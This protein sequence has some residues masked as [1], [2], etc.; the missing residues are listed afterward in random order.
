MKPTHCAFPRN[1]GIAAA[2]LLTLGT[3][4]Q[5]YEPDITWP[6]MASRTINTSL[7]VG[8]IAGVPSVTQTGAA[9][10]TIPILVPPGTNGVVPQL[11][12]VYNSQGG[13][14]LL[15]YG[16]NLS[17]LST[18]SRTGRD[19]YH[20]GATGP[21]TLSNDDRF[22]LDGQ[23]L[24]CIS[25]TY[26]VPGSTYDTESTSFA[27]I[28]LSSNGNTEA[29]WYFSV[30]TK[31]GITME[32]GLDWNA[33]ILSNAEDKAIAWRLNRT[34]DVYGNYIDYLYSSNDGDSWLTEVRYT[35][36]L[37]SFSAPYNNITF[38]YQDRIDKNEQFMA[39]EPLG[40][41]NLLSGITVSAH[42]SLVRAYKLN[43][44][45]RYN[46][47][48]YLNEVQE[49]GSDGIKSYNPTQFL[50]NTKG[51]T[52]SQVTTSTPQTVESDIF[53][54]D[55]DGNGQ[56]DK[57]VAR[58]IWNN[59]YR[60]HDYFNIYLNGSTQASPGGYHDFTT[61]SEIMMADSYWRGLSSN[62]LDG[63]GRDDILISNVSLQSSIVPNDPLQ[64]WSNYPAAW[65]FESFTVFMSTSTINNAS[66]SPPQQFAPPSVYSYFKKPENFL[67]LGDFTGDGRQDA[68]VIFN[69]KNNSNVSD[70]FLFSNNAW[71]ALNL[72]S[73]TTNMVSHV[74]R[75]LGGDYDGDG[76]SELFALTDHIPG[77]PMY[78]AL[79]INAGN[80]LQLVKGGLFR[81]HGA[82][83]KFYVHSGDF[84]G[85]H[86]TDFLVRDDDGIDDGSEDDW[87]IYTG[88]G[89]KDL[90]LP[91]YVSYQ[92]QLTDAF[93]GSQDK[94]I[95]ADFD[96]NG[97][98]DIFHNFNST[99][100]N[101]Q[102]YF[103]YGHD[104][105]LPIFD[106]SVSFYCSKNLS[107][108][109][110]GDFNGDAKHDL[111]CCNSMNTELTSIQFDPVSRERIL[112]AVSN[113]LCERVDFNYGTLNELSGSQYNRGSQYEYPL[114]YSQ[115]PLN[116]VANIWQ[117][118]GLGSQS[119]TWY[120]YDMAR[121]HRAG[122]G[123]LGFARIRAH[124]SEL[125]TTVETVKDF[126][127]TY[128][129][130]YVT[131]EY[132]RAYS[133]QQLISHKNYQYQYISLGP[134]SD[135]RFYQK[136]TNTT[137][138]NGLS[139]GTV[140]TTNVWDAYGNITWCIQN[141]SN[142]LLTT[143]TSSTFAHYGPGLSIPNRIIATTVTTI[144]DGQAALSKATSF[145][146]DGTTGGLI[147]LK[148]F[149]GTGKELTTDYT[150]DGRGL[151]T[152]E[153]S[154][155]AGASSLEHRITDYGY[156]ALGQFVDERTIQWNNSGTLVPVVD[157]FAYDAKWGVPLENTGP[158][159][160]T[161]KYT[162]DVFGRGI[163]FSVPHVDGSPRYSITKDLDWALGGNEYY[164]E[165][166]EHP[167]KPVR[168]TFYDSFGRSVRKRVEVNGPGD[169]SEIKITYDVRG[170]VF[171]E[172]QA[173]L[174]NEQYYTVERQYDAYNR[175]TQEA[176][177]VFGATSYDYNYDGNGAM[178]RTV[179]S[180]SGAAQESTTD[181]SGLLTKAVDGGGEQEYTYDSW[182]NLLRVRLNGSTASICKYDAYGRQTSLWDP[183]AGSTTYEYDA[184]GQLVYQEDAQS[185]ITTFGYD[186]LGR[187]V[188][189]DI[190]GEVTTWDY[191]FDGSKFS[192]DLRR[193]TGHAA[194][195][196]YEYDAYF[197]VLKETK[198]ISGSPFTT[199]FEYDDYNNAT[200]Q[201]YPSGLEIDYTYRADGCIDK[202]AYNG[203][204]LFG[205][206]G[207][208]G[209]GQYLSYT[210]GS[211]PLSYKEYYYGLPTHFQTAGIQD[212]QM[213]WDPNTLNLNYRWDKMKSRKE[214]FAYDML[215][216][217]TLSTVTEVDG[218]GNVVAQ[219][220]ETDFNYDGNIG[221][222]KGNLTWKTDV[223]QFKYNANKVTGAVN[224]AYPTPAN[225]PPDV[226]N[227]SPQNI[228]YTP[229]HQPAQI[230]ENVN[231]TDYSLEYEY[232]ADLHRCHSTLNAGGALEESR[233]Y[234]G[235]FE[236]QE[237]VSEGASREIHYVYGGDGIC[238]VLVTEGGATQIYHVFKDH[239]GSLVALVQEAGGT[240]NISAEQNFDA[241][242]R[243][244]NAQDWSTSG[245]VSTPSW[246]Y[247]GYTGH[248]HVEPFAL[249]NMNG[250]MYDPINGRML[251]PDNYAIGTY[252]SQTFNRYSYANNNPLKYTD[253]DGNVAI[254][255]DAILGLI[256]G[257]INLVSN[258]GNISSF[259]QGLGYFGIGFISGASSTYITPMGAAALAGALNAGFDSY[260]STGKVNAGAMI[261]G[262]VISGALGA[263]T[264]GL[265]NALA[266]LASKLLPGVASPVLRGAATQGILGAGLGGLGGGV[267]AALSGGN[268]W[269]GVGQGAAFGAA[270]GMA[271][272]AYGGFLTARA[273]GVDPWTGRAPPPPVPP[274]EP[275]KGGIGPVLKGQ[276]GVE[277]AINELQ[278]EG[279][280]NIHTEITFEV[281]GTRIRVD[282]AGEFNGEI[283]LYEVKTGPA[284]DL[285]RNQ[286]IAFPLMQGDVPIIPF[287][288][289][290]IRAG[291]VPG[292]EIRGYILE[293][294]RYK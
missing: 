268:V 287:G 214:T 165:H 172:S 23:R 145:S 38:T 48:S 33:K 5:P 206:L 247:R 203:Q 291:F 45:W 230:T 7:E 169:W 140:V 132:L 81:M 204:E 192:N 84:N 188:K 288:Q 226:I 290:A 39:G 167:G 286:R 253:P 251:S 46:R 138:L 147:Q 31:D 252:A 283:R 157:R 152:R 107:T 205:S 68:I 264:M 90:Y 153:D 70:A 244:R 223:G 99:P 121:I 69:D 271:T 222:T 108:I 148:T 40:M 89:K 136:L 9:T 63:D 267:G 112:A 97:L 135:K 137:E 109:T 101:I 122:R 183:N 50:Y 231:S 71:T 61:P 248:E 125:N 277:R 96:G 141:V 161:K 1:V 240:F 105:Q 190:A 225:L 208:N 179:T 124:N 16:W 78:Y 57:L 263:M 58:V 281:S 241:W 170:N 74:D 219:V 158:D 36:H 42:G 243:R 8:T 64:E 62:D 116:V 259:G 166:I 59:G 270:T 182:G 131:D 25:G 186:N 37:Y 117:P 274:A 216:R 126:N 95:V 164:V 160:L 199:S 21:I 210:M 278:L 3:Q 212:L 200:K 211:L 35:G 272:G 173:H 202:V 187:R 245:L 237:V 143:V 233:W 262:A 56:S 30:V 163:E 151:L 273:Q 250:R 275:S 249:I 12:L 260:N 177:D 242:G 43:Y 232:G 261:Q 256:G 144:R 114:N 67:Q 83:E 254:V 6:G 29:F 220:S 221:E 279:V 77:Q 4:G 13:N 28:T 100:R 41:S 235:G 102:L 87:Y 60:C 184:Y 154:H 34:I 49:F 282:I 159:G 189:R 123:F 113:G 17:G 54:G 88:T 265:G 276:R 181:A 2:V 106:Q 197:R 79:G 53:S 51:G 14:G 130:P 80:N 92:F 133:D 118:D 266:P 168:E 146:Y 227:L 213:D 258:W 75:L 82:D 150:L 162:Y 72:D 215:D 155:A 20:D 47:G 180:P 246:L 175:L 52:Y 238:A 224:L 142:W 193:V 269:Q 110:V 191:F 176:N 115:I 156:D 171:S 234:V 129:T 209:Q 185:N 236:K 196:E 32:Y 86:I 18:I 207:L 76:K 85:D 285:T 111:V 149:P 280:T 257:V 284:A 120:E 255:D 178:T 198:T 65:K 139:G 27:S 127:L 294:R 55:F 26:G 239:L 98:S 217:L 10:Y 24:V 128:Y 194:N 22:A 103:S 293:I 134:A 195:Y 292:Q 11:A 94:L 91:G 218:G 93:D 228:T 104:G 44:S 119:A 289:N 201:T 229:F 73:W 66:F 19:Q 15:G 174:A